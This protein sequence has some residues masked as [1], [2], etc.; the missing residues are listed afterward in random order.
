L[1]AVFHTDY[2]RLPILEIR[3]EIGAAYFRSG[4]AGVAFSKYIGLNQLMNITFSLEN[5]MF[6]PDYIT[7]DRLRKKI[8][9]SYFS[10]GYSYRINTLDTKN[11]PNTGLLSQISVNTSRLSSAKII[12]DNYRTKYTSEFP[13][14]FPFKRSYSV[15]GDFKRYFSPNRK[16]TFVAGWNALFTHTKDSTTS[17]HNYY[18]AGGQESACS[19]SITLTGFHPGEIAVDR[20]AGVSFNADLEFHEDLHL[21]LLTNIAIARETGQ[22]RNL[23]ILGGYGLEIGYMSIIGPVRIG[24]MQGISKYD[25]YFS[26]FKGFISIGFS[27]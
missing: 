11:F 22:G 24:L 9:Y 15:A 4:Y 27:F 19:R 3:N 7:Q 6:I 10:G 26:A 20:Y 18:F 2:T 23:S 25:R 1:S 5:N 13:G 17:P 14:D 12:T 16:L 8:S 21:G